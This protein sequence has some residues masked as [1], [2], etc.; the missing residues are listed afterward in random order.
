MENSAITNNYK[1]FLDYLN[2]FLIWFRMDKMAK[3]LGKEY[4]ILELYFFL[5]LEH[6]LLYGALLLFL[7][8]LD[9]Q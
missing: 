1:Y 6:F 3:L 8:S 7:L 5:I 4:D 9:Q 2:F